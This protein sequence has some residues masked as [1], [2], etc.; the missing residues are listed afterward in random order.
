MIQRSSLPKSVTN[1]PWHTIL[2]ATLTLAFA[3]LAQAQTPAVSTVLAFSGSRVPDG[4][5]LGPDGVLYGASATTTGETGGLI[6]RSAT[7]GSSVE[8]LY[9]FGSQDGISPAGA[10]L[11]GSDGL[12]YGTT[13][14]SNGGTSVG[15]G[16][17]FRV[18]TDGT[19]FTTL[20]NFAPSTSSNVNSN[21]INADGVSPLAALIE[22]SDGFLYGVTRFGG[23]AGAGTVYKIGKDGSGF[24]LLHAFAAITSAAS[25]VIVNADGAHPRA[26]LA[27]S[28]GFFYGTTNAGGAN[29]QGTIFRL[30]FDGSGFELLH[31]FTT[32]VAP[33]GSTVAVNEHGAAPQAGLTDGNDGLLYGTT[34]Q[35]GANGVGVLYSITPNGSVITALHDFVAES[36]TQPIGTLLLASDGK[37]YGTTAAGGTTS[38]GGASTL[39][40]VFSFDPVGT[41]YTNLHNF[42]STTGSNGNGTM[43]QLNSTEFIGTA[44]NGGRCGSGTIFRLS[45]AGTTVT[46]DTSCGSSSGGGGG[47]GATSLQLLLMLGALLLAGSIRRRPGV[48]GGNHA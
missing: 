11:L 38:S 27:E 32:P 8:T 26:A 35:G 25:A 14:F 15:G 13:Q 37:L 29:G 47:G 23:P 21:P 7:D 1:T 9:Q 20:H 5:I 28:A 46:G 31:V 24:S 48:I 43:V 17:V 10:L 12:L 39:G 41:G 36:G 18:A 44:T 33:S 19:G 6:F 45:L 34:V 2:F 16:T 4:V 3:S 40:T 22:G 30:G 42:D